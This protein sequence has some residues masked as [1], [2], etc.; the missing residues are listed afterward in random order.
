MREAGFRECR[1]ME[2]AFTPNHRFYLNDRYGN[3]VIATIE[4]IY[5]KNTES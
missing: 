2:S 4:E 1:G 3:R 5:N